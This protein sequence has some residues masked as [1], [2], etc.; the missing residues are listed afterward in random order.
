MVPGIEKISLHIF[1]RPSPA[2]RDRALGA[3]LLTA[4]AANAVAVAYLELFSS[5]FYRFLWTVALA[6]ATPDA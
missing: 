3:E 2:H 5:D 6:D 1:E 4:E